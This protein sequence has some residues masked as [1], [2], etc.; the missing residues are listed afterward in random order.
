MIVGGVVGRGVAALLGGN[1]RHGVA[2]QDGA[3]E[4]PRYNL[5]PTTMCGMGAWRLKASH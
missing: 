5:L 4:R 1:M 3:G 2:E